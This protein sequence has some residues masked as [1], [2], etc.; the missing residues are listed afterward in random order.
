MVSLLRGQKLA[1]ADLPPIG[2]CLERINIFEIDLE[3]RDAASENAK[4]GAQA[5][6]SW[7]ACVDDPLDS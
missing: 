7:F 2:G 5:P 1:V 6:F 4:T 3:H